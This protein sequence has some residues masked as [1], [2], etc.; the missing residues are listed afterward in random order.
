MKDCAEQAERVVKQI[1]ASQIELGSSADRLMDWENHYS[2]KYG[3]C[4]FRASYISHDLKQGKDVGVPPFT[5]E[6]YD[7]FEGRVLSRC[8]GATAAKLA[9]S[10]CHVDDDAAPSEGD[11]AACQLYADEH[12]TK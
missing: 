2:P 4:Y 9:K 10:F 5:S 7:A 3:R 8:T 12:M 1:K 6:I 11:C